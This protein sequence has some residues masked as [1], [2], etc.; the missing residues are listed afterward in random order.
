MAQADSLRLE[1]LH[2]S[3]GWREVG[4]ADSLPSL[5]LARGARPGPILDS[6]HQSGLD[7]IPLDIPDDAIHL[8]ILADPMIVRLILPERFARASEDLSCLAS[9]VTLDCST[10]LL[11]LH[12]GSEQ[13]VDVVGH[14]DPRPQIVFL[15]NAL[16]EQ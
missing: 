12:M 13:D 14:D 4:Q 7:R 10:H 11:H 6:L 16:T 2:L 3:I 8:L 15:P 9:A 1:F 5:E